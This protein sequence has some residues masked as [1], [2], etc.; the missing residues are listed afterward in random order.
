M[1]KENP[2]YEEGKGVSDGFVV[3]ELRP[4]S[5][6]SQILAGLAH[7]LSTCVIANGIAI[8]P[9]TQPHVSRVNPG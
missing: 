4:V 1:M 2:G 8:N 9:W 5:A 3:L 6:W 7:F